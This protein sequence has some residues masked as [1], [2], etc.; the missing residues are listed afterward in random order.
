MQIAMA[1]GETTPIFFIPIEPLSADTTPHH[2]LFLGKA[3]TPSGNYTAH[4]SLSAHD[5]PT[6]S[7]LYDTVVV[8]LKF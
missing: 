2:I 8:N 4:F 6:N 7:T 3:G 5:D 1:N